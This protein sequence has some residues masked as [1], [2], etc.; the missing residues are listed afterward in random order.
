MARTLY[1]ILLWLALPVLGIRLALRAAKN[2]GYRSRIAE[3]FG[4]AGGDC[5]PCELL[6]PDWVVPMQVFV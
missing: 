5:V 6:H 3:R 4:G 1:T 2:P